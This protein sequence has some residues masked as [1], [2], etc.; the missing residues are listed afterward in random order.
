MGRLCAV[1]PSSVVSQSALVVSVSFLV[2]GFAISVAVL[3]ESPSGVSSN[4]C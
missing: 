3:S 2:F 4:I 1:V